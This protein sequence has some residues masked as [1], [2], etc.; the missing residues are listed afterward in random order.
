M[1][2]VASAPVLGLLMHVICCEVL[3]PFGNSALSCHALT[4]SSGACLIV[5]LLL[6]VLWLFVCLCVCFTR[7][8]WSVGGPS[9]VAGGLGPS[10]ALA[11]HV[12]WAEE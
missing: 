6:F 9:F 10:C 1:K 4:I 8:P 7:R 12:L 5:F 3:V 11:G 2:I